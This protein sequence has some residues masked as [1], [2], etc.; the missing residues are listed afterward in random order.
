MK[1]LHTLLI[2]AVAAVA[3]PF[4]IKAQFRYAPIAGVTINNLN[5]KQDLFDVDKTVGVQAGIMGEM[6]FPGIG[7]G[8]DLGL[9]YN[10]MGAKTDLGSREIWSSD[11]YRRS[12]V[13]VHS[14]QIPVHLRFKWTRMQGL[15]DYIAPFVYGGPD[16]DIVV[17]HNK[18]KGNANA[19]AP[20]KYAGGDL[21]L[22]CGGGVELLKR[23]QV[24]F[25][26]TWGMTYILKTSKLDNF[27]AK[28]RQWAVRVAY[29]F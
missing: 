5:F 14:I 11:G 27:T 2:I 4:T 12:T 7:F 18:I 19:T 8:I 24:S 13:M 23:W 17:G 3:I 25:H 21:G 10:Q 20:Y 6:M 1:R 15:E 28:N 29:M 9:L 26:Y 22:T 16:F